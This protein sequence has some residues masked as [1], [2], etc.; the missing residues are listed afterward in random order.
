MSLP[1]RRRP[2]FERLT[3]EAGRTGAP[4]ESSRSTS[5]AE[6]RE[7]V[8]VELT[9]LF[10]A[11]ALSAAKDVDLGPHVE[12]SAL[13]YGLPDLSGKTASSIDLP[14]FERKLAA[15]IRWFEPRLRPDS[16][17]VHASSSGPGAH[18]ILSFKID[19]NLAA[20]PAERVE[21]EAEFELETGTAIVTERP[22]RA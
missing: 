7:S 1:S 16:V 8:R 20:N 15:S 10:N 18:N 3:N 5:A 21:L 22:R 13:N 17:Q 11:T 6:L 9:F 19:A 12:R 4:I 2:L 14:W